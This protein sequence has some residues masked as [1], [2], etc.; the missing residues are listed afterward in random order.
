MQ[1]IVGPLSVSPDTGR[2]ESDL[3]PGQVPRC[4]LP[5]TATREVKPWDSN[6]HP[7]AV[8]RTIPVTEPR[9]SNSEGEDFVPAQMDRV[10][11]GLSWGSITPPFGPDRLVASEVTGIPY[12][13]VTRWLPPYPVGSWR[14]IYPPRFSETLSA[15]GDL[16][17][18]HICRDK[19]L[20]NRAP[21]TPAR[22]PPRGRGSPPS[23]GRGRGACC[24]P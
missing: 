23:T 17:A 21:Q 24:T 10:L 4:R 6:N 16:D 3:F 13:G 7:S 14:P 19:D 1:G 15:E 12:G 2:E 5:P 11:A 22:P 9:L 18:V 20:G 8:R